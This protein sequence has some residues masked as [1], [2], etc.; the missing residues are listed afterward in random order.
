MD[1]L[2]ARDKA[3]AEATNRAKEQQEA[4]SR[5]VAFDQGGTRGRE[6][7][8]YKMNS[9]SGRY[10]EVDQNV[11]IARD[12]EQKAKTSEIKVPIPTLGTVA[13]GTISSISRNQQAKALRSGG[14]AVFDSSV[15]PSSPMFDPV[16]DYRGVVSTNSLGMST[17]SGD[18]SF[19]PIGRND[20]KKTELGS[21]SVS[22]KSDDGSDNPT[23]TVISP[24]PKDVTE[25]IKKKS[26]TLSTASR[27]AML[28]GSGGG[29]SRR[30]LL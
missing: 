18:P 4:K 23:E 12:L 6:S 21:Y 11:R 7:P 8:E 29:A 10:R 28:S 30:N 13:M 27:R 19:S 24:K 9:G 15:D 22:A 16:K 1:S 26:P 3:M 2:R 17:Y 25:P 14:R 20:T 5:Q